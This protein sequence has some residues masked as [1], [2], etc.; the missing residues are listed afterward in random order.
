MYLGCAPP[1]TPPCSQRGALIYA[2]RPE[3]SRRCQKGIGLPKKSEFQN[4]RVMSILTQ[5]VNV[6]SDTDSECKF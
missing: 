5:T 4:T 1:N 2:R 3:D 6:N